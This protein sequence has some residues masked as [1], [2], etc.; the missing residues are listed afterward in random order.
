[1]K[2]ASKRRRTPRQMMVAEARA[3]LEAQA[4][5]KANAIPAPEPELEPGEPNPASDDPPVTP[6]AASIKRWPSLMEECQFGLSNLHD[7][8]RALRRLPKPRRRPGDIVQL[9]VRLRRLADFL[10]QA[11]VADK[12]GEAEGGQE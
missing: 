1:K 9:V 4:R 8:A 11:I 5:E 2:R 12:S 10:E 3:A 7:Q 6:A